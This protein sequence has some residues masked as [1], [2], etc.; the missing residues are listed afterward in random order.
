MFPWT[1][2]RFSEIKRANILHF[3]KCLLL[4]PLG[5]SP[6]CPCA[7]PCCSS[8]SIPA[9]TGIRGGSGLRLIQRNTQILGWSR[10]DSGSRS[11]G[12]SCALWQSEGLHL[13]NSPFGN[14]L[15]LQGNWGVRKKIRVF[16]LSPKET[17]EPW[18]RPDLN[19]VWIGETFKSCEPCAYSKHNHVY[20]RYFHIFTHFLCCL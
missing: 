2:Q 6:C 8:P 4:F 19:W 16:R 9:A 14:S 3:S 20:N 18:F 5:V 1:R 13:S 7:T 11:T 10:R 15:K 12:M 17:A